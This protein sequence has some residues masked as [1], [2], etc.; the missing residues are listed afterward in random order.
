MSQA[1]WDKQAPARGEEAA[2]VEVEAAPK[3]K[4]A[5]KAAK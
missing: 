4:A 5:K 3:K 1:L 2:V